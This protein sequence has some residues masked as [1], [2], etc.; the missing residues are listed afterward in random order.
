MGHPEEEGYY[1][2][3]DQKHKKTK[4]AKF[5]EQPPKE[6]LLKPTNNNVVLS[7]LNSQ[8]NFKSREWVIQKMEVKH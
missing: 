5:Q 2:H 7:C 6:V 3:N 4:T 8:A 1:K